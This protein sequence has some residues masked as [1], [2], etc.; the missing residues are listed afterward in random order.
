MAGRAVLQYLQTL[1]QNNWQTDVTG[2][3]QSVP[4]PAIVIAADAQ[5]TRVSQYDRDVVFVTEG[6]PQSLTP[7]GV[8]WGHREVE[9]LATID[10]RTQRSRSRLE[11][12]RDDNNEVEDHGGLR[13]EVLRIL[14]VHR[15]G[16]KEFDLIEGYEYTPLSEEVGYQFWRGAWEVRLSEKARNIDPQP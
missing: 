2:R 4:E 14:D 8:G 16:D 5:T 7:K 15:K 9:T 6:G 1:L 11:G 13:G 3:T 10:C 12:V